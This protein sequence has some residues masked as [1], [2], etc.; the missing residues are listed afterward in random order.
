MM[1]TISLG[2]LIFTVIVMMLVALILVARSWLIPPG[3]EA[4]SDEEIELIKRPQI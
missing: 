1:I 3:E 4:L 2:V